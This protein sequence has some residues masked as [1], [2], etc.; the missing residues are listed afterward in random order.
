M[1]AI[2]HEWVLPLTATP[3]RCQNQHPPVRLAVMTTDS[4]DDDGCGDDGS[5]EEEDNEYYDT[6]DS[7]DSGC[8]DD[9]SCESES[10]ESDEDDD[11]DSGCNDD[12]S[13]ESDSYDATYDDDDRYSDD[14]CDC[15]GGG[16]VSSD[17]P[18][19]G[20]YNGSLRLSFTLNFDARVSLYITDNAGSVLK[21]IVPSYSKMDAGLYS[22]SWNGE[23]GNGQFMTPGNYQAVLETDLPRRVVKKSFSY[24]DAHGFS[25]NGSSQNTID[26]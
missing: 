22:Y 3:K 1:S 11:D 9:G 7:D 6:S 16:T 26:F 24:S 10:Y 13:C 18:S 2:R 23:Y 12:G 25:V 19:S 5:C 17:G 15:S 20:Y 21:S 4:D 14:G 8:N